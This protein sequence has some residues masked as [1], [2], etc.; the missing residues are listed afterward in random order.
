MPKMKMRG[1]DISDIQWSGIQHA[2]AAQGLTAACWIRQVTQRALAC[3][4]LNSALSPMAPVRPSVT[5][6]RVAR[7]SKLV[8]RK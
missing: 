4:D 8:D 2:A 7:Q 5:G 1:F 6:Q 3:P